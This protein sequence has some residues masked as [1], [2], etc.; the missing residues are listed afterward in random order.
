[1]SVVSSSADAEGYSARWSEFW[2]VTPRTI[3]RWRKAHAAGAMPF[4][5]DDVDGMLRWSLGP[6]RKPPAFLTRCAE[7]RVKREKR[8]APPSS[9]SPPPS[10]PGADPASST[11]AHLAANSD[12]AAFQA[13][14]AAAA[15]SAPRDAAAQIQDL[16]KHLHFAEFALRRARERGDEVAQKKY[17]AEVIQFSRAV[18]EQKLLADRLGIEAGELLPRSTVELLVAA[19]GYWAMRSIDQHLDYLSRRLLN[20]SYPEEARAVLEP[21]LLSARF[22]APFARATHLAARNSLPPWL[23][24]A[25]RATVADYIEHGAAAFDRLLTAAATTDPTPP[26]PAPPSTPPTP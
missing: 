19:F 3:Q 14:L 18:K 7:L 10:A 6:E 4:A 26:P 21:E 25:L 9:D 20:L 22:V 23:T 2:R 1:M 15:G 5:P 12:W 16:E 17:V 24:A 8:P 13:H 11:A